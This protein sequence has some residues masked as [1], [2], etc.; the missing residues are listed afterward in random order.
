MPPR[1]RAAMGRLFG[2]DQVAMGADRSKRDEYER[3]MA[4]S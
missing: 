2:V 4:A 1:G 3:R